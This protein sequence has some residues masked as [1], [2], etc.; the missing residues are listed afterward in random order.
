MLLG[1]RVSSVVSVFAALGLADALA[2]EPKGVSTLAQTCDASEGALAR[3]LRAAAVLELVEVTSAGDFRLTALG[4]ALRSDA[5]GSLRLLASSVTREDRWRPWGALLHSVRTGAPAFEAIFGQSQD[6]WFA[7]HRDVGEA[8]DRQMTSVTQD[9]ATRCAEAIDPSRFSS[10]IDVGGGEGVL[11]SAVLQR[12]PSARG[13]LF[14]LPH[15]VAGARPLLAEAGVTERCTVVGG[16][17]FDGVPQDGDAY[18]LK[19]ILHGWDDT[20]CLQILNSCC[21]A[22][23]GGSRLFV[24]ETLLPSGADPER[25]C[26]RDLNMLV[27]GSGRERTLSEYEELL[28]RAGLDVVAVH[29]TSS[30]FSL[31]EA[32]LR[33]TAQR[34]T[35]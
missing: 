30:Q 12:A 13:V 27:M 5:P 34:G 17:F 33:P 28:D 26:L 1:S 23:G 21:A 24:I 31:I 16:S 18:L 25:I 15:V 3:L 4:E 20:Q 22:M 7:D 2:G 19:W 10:V 29:P 14:D 11:L 8:F 32:G 9:I 35:G 6:E